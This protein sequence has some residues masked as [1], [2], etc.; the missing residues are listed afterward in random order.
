MAE[1]T[2]NDIGKKVRWGPKPTFEVGYAT[3]D[4]RGTSE[5]MVE[6]AVNEFK[7]GD[8]IVPEL[9]PDLRGVVIGATDDLY[10][11]KRTDGVA[12][13]NGHG[14][15]LNWGV[16]ASGDVNWWLAK[17]SARLV[18][19]AST[20][21]TNSTNSATPAQPNGV[22]PEPTQVKP[23]FKK[24]DLVQKNAG[25]HECAR[26]S[27]PHIIGCRS[28]RHR[29]ALEVME[30]TFGDGLIWYVL[31]TEDGSV[32]GNYVSEGGLEPVYQ[33]REGMV[34]WTRPASDNA[35]VPIGIFETGGLVYAVVDNEIILEKPQPK[36]SEIV[37]IG[38]SSTKRK[39]L[40][41]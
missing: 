17:S 21:S 18:K 9:D 23:R 27:A 20:P 13:H 2:K 31:R 25:G 35:T 15:Q 19:R 32:Y 29:D 7:Y 38:K 22:S 39:L 40:T 8:E 34:D 14:G 10:L 26:S 4:L 30:S 24:G 16:P 36:E 33:E 5:P 41:F 28:N 11:I 3:G 37:Y 1:F 6:P 12:G